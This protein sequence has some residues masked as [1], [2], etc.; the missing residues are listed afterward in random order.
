MEKI[1]LNKTYNWEDVDDLER[2]IDEA[3][4]RIADM[5]HTDEWEGQIRVTITYIP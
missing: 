2:D 4:D 3:A 1:V 5:Q